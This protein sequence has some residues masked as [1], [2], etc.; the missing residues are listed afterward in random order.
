MRFAT[1]A[2]RVGQ[3][4][5]PTTRSVIVPIYQTATFAFHEIGQHAGYEYTRTGNPTRTALEKCLASLE[6]GA[7]GLAFA[8]GSA[9]T[10]AA[11][12]I[13]RPGDHVVAASQIYGGT[14]RIFESL[15]KPEGSISPTLTPILQPTSSV[16]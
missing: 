4:P 8:S 7:F 1:K 11:L 9:A 14:F 6:D 16:L 12:S 13:L 2:I 10:D 3:T 5:E 15:M